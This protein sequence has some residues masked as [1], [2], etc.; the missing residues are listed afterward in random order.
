[1]AYMRNTGDISP[2][3]SL[4][5]TYWVTTLQLL[6]VGIPWEAILS[7]TESELNMVV[8]VEAALQQREADDQAREMSRSNMKMP[9]NMR[10]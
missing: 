8:G 1:M 2:I 9:T 7:F 4:V 5:Y 10:M 6:K 3:E